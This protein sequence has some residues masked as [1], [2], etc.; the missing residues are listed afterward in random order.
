MSLLDTLENLCAV[1]IGGSLRLVCSKCRREEVIGSV[2]AEMAPSAAMK[3]GWYLGDKSNTC[4]ECY[5]AVD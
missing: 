3:R 5:S 2:N 4:K 1:A